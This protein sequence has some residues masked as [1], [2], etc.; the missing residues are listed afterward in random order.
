VRRRRLTADGVRPVGA[1]QHACDWG[2]LDG[3]VAPTTGERC[4]R[5]WPS[6]KAQTCPLVVEA[7]AETCPDRLNLLLLEKRGAPPAQQLRGPE[8]VRCV[9]LPPYGPEL[10]PLERLWRDLT[11][12]LAWQ[13]VPN[14]AAPHDSVGQW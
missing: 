1:V 9:G 6:R 12:D 7:L 13:Q 2:A 4:F 11:D 3:A 10:N 14:V 5:G 8:T